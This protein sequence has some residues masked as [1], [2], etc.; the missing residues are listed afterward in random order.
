MRLTVYKILC[1]VSPVEFLLAASPFVKVAVIHK[2][3]MNT[4]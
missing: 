2:P 1:T 4:L 3:K